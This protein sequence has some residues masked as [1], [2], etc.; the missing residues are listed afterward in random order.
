MLDDTKERYAFIFDEDFFTSQEL[1]EVR[2]KEKNIEEEKRFKP[3]SEYRSFDYEVYVDAL[4]KTNSMLDVVGNFVSI[5][6]E[7]NKTKELEKQI[8]SKEKALDSLLYET[9]KRADI[10]LKEEKERY[11]VEIE[12]MKKSLDN[13]LEKVKSEA[14]F[15]K[16]KLNLDYKERRE[17]IKTFENARKE[18]LESL[19]FTKK[20]INNEDNIKNKYYLQVNE[21]Y[22]DCLEL[23]N[24]LVKNYVKGGI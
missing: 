13:S 2:K 17:K 16:Y 1:E 23:Y 12:Y 9:V 5:Y 20:I 3:V 18:I 15:S 19:N 7:Y 4:N 14:E 6:E 11:N 22:R 10:Y 21:T 24:N 8:E